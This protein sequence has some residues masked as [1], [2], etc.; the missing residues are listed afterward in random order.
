MDLGKGNR[1]KRLIHAHDQRQ[2]SF[3][4]KLWHWPNSS[5]MREKIGD[6]R[7]PVEQ[8][9]VERYLEVIHSGMN[10]SDLAR[11]WAEGQGLTVD[12]A[13]TLALKE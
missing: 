3:M 12:E 11:L 7:P 5:A 9:S 2:M 6:P 13:V 8:A 4:R 10:D 1:W